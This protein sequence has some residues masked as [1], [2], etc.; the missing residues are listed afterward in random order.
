M[1][2]VTVNTYK[3]PTA[4]NPDCP[5]SVGIMNLTEAEAGLVAEFA[6]NVRGVPWTRTKDTKAMRDMT[7]TA[8][9]ERDTMMRANSALVDASGQRC[10]DMCDIPEQCYKQNFCGRRW[11]AGNL[12][13]E[14]ARA[15]GLT[16]SWGSPTSDPELAMPGNRFSGL[17][18]P[19]A[20]KP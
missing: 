3:T 13:D 10:G 1:K 12:R 15:Q 19:D 16:S 7:A 8:M 9:R 4:D 5:W 14:A 17:D 2:T 11:L 20:D 18:I 6:R